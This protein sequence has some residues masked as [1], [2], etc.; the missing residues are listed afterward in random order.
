MENVFFSGYWTGAHHKCL[1][2]AKEITYMELEM[3]KVSLSI[4]FQLWS[5]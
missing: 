1:L 4:N 3:E 2:Q 5:N